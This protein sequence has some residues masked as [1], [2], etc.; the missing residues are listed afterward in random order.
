MG[1]R[2]ARSRRDHAGALHACAGVL[3]AG[4]R[5]AGADVRPGGLELELV[6]LLPEPGGVVLVIV[7]ARELTKIFEE[8]FRGT[9][10]EAL[11]HFQQK[12]PKGEFVILLGSA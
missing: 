8:F 10:Q 4:S 3:R 1:G 6:E 11:Q 5:R 2:F 7:V 9:P 12:P